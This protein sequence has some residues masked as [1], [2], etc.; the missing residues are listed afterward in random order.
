MPYF[1]QAIGVHW[2]IVLVVSRSHIYIYVS[3]VFTYKLNITMQ[4]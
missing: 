2:K 1:L 4:I 3:S